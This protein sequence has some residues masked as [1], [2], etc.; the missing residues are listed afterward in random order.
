MDLTKSQVKCFTLRPRDAGKEKRGQIVDWE[1]CVGGGDKVR[2]GEI[3]RRI[4]E[5]RIK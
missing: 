4:K 3:L 2:N 1:T 5:A